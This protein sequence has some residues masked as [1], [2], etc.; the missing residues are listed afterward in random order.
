[1]SNPDDLR[2]VARLFNLDALVLSE[3]YFVLTFNWKIPKAL[4]AGS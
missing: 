4:E 2:S 3:Y 1:M